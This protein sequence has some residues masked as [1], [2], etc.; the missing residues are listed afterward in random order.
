M[1]FKILKA[2]SDTLLPAKTKS[3]KKFS[4]IQWVVQ[5]NND[6]DTLLMVY[7]MNSLIWWIVDKLAMKANIWFDETWNEILDE[8]LA[9]ID[10]E[11]LFK[12]LLIFWVAFFERLENLRW[13]KT[14]KLEPILTTQMRVADENIEA[15]Y[16]YLD[17]NWQTIYFQ[18]EDILY[19][20]RMSVSD[21]YYWDWLFTKAVD[22]LLLLTF[23]I[24]YYK[25]FFSSWAI[26][27]N[28]LYDESWNLTDEQLKQIEELIKSKIEWVDKAHNT[29]FVK[30]K[31][32]KVDLA[33]N[34]DPDKFIALKRELK[35]DIAIATNIPFALLS[36]ENSNRATSQTALKMLYN[37][38]VMPLQTRVAKQLQLQLLQWKE[39]GKCPDLEKISEDDIKKIKFK[40]VNLTDPKEE[41]EI[42][43]SYQ[44]QWVFSINEVREKLGK[45]PISGWDEHII[46]QWNIENAVD[47]N[48]EKTFKDLKQAYED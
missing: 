9:E 18:K 4:N 26:Q 46:F 22:E 30:W 27:P 17:D 41:M 31:I 37:D 3:S 34:I 2:V 25:K 43:T 42:L 28:V 13:E 33:S 47:S 23:I 12:N 32:W 24:K 45:D 14:L 48:I 8:F 7:E 40:N 36:P 15:D 11:F 38:V 29:V 44:R 19:F 21:K 10:L 6:F 1:K 20:K 16:V 5:P 39:A 35:E